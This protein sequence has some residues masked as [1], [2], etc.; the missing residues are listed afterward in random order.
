MVRGLTAWKVSRS[1][2]KE[3][4]REWT[5]HAHQI[6]EISTSWNLLQ[7]AFFELFW[8]VVANHETEKHSMVHA[9]WHT[10]QSDKTQREMLEN[11]SKNHPTLSKRWR[12]NIKWATKKAYDL[13]KVRNDSIHTPVQFAYLP[14][15]R[16]ILR[17]QKVSAKKQAVDR[18]TVN[19]TATVWRAVRGDLV[20]LANYCH[21]MSSSYV[22]HGPTGP[23]PRKPPLQSL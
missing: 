2:P 8:I 6:G 14:N 16:P 22:A 13:S 3:I 7:D 12:A 15:A 10:I 23:L 11:I 18:L 5:R 21:A 9:L 1:I 17:L 4:R 20:A 19:P